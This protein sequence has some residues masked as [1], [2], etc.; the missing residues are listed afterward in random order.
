MSQF[1]YG[2]IAGG[3]IGVCIGFMVAALL[4]MAGRER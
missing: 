1:V 2:L 4:A 3:F